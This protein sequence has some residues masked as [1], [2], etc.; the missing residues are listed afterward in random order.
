VPLQSD[1][2][3]ESL[4]SCLYHVACA[5]L[6]FDASPQDVSDAIFI[7]TD[8]WSQFESHPSGTRF[9][10]IALNA[11]HRYILVRPSAETIKAA[12][13]RQRCAIAMLQQCAPAILL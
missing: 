8:V 10:A 3:V 12:A 9:R 7:F 13:H 1:F 11:V 2:R 4:L 5:S 6:S